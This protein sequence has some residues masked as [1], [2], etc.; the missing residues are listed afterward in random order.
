VN[1][2]LGLHVGAEDGV[3]AGLVAALLVEPAEQICVEAERKGASV[4]LFIPRLTPSRACH[5]EPF[6]AAI[7]GENG[8]SLH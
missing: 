4:L 8:E 6:G 1:G 2:N 3:D 7:S 5:S